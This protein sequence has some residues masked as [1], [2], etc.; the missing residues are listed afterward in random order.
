[1]DEK[2]SAM[3]ERFLQFVWKFGLYDSRKLRT[4]DG[5]PV[6][7]LSPGQANTDAGPDFFNARIQIGSTVWAGN[8]EV[9]RRSSEWYSH[10]H[11]SNAAYNNVVL[12]VVKEADKPTRNEK[13][14]DIPVLVLHYPEHIE[15]N[16]NELMKAKGWIVCQNQFHKV[17][18]L[19]LQIWFHSIMIERLQ[20][21]TGILLERLREN[22]MDWNETFYQF[23]GKNFG[24]K[25]NSV[26]FEMLCRALP[27]K[28]VNKHADNLLQLEALFFGAAGLL[29]EELIGDDYFISLKNEFSFLYKKYQFQT[30]PAHLWK[31]LR[32]RPV[33]FPTI[34]IAQ[35]A[36]L[37]H[38]S[39][40]LFSQLI[41]MPNPDSL[42]K[43]FR[44]KASSYWDD[45]YRFNRSSSEDEK[46]LGDSSFANI[47]IN[48]FVPFLFVYAE[49]NSKPELKDKALDFLEKI[50]PENNSI[51]DNWKILG[52]PMR[53]SF[54]TQALLQL[55]NEYCDKRKC[56]NCPVGSKIVKSI[57]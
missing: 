20:Q 25:T 32:L 10:K 57:T 43:I 8:V 50:P 33:N 49:Y 27:L 37:M 55:K 29:N 52:V 17:D 7:V 18:L 51:I 6:K 34:R 39:S 22:D 26:P 1:M 12:H 41:E 2:S 48:T 54:D 36:A 19:S 13:L 31:F 53:S 15:V 35:F 4:V 45:H 23:L 11:E 47:V 5:T 44:V 30:V 24:F 56:L 42:K 46:W 28:I 21:K 40:F 14:Q 9:H 3:D 38:Q 16:Y